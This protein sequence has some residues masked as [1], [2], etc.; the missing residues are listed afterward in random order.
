MRMSVGIGPVRVYSGGG[1]RRRSRYWNVAPCTVRHTRP[2]ISARCAQCQRGRAIRSANVA[3]RRRKAVA[4]AQ[5]WREYREQHDGHMSPSQKA[6]VA[7]FVSG[8]ILVLVVIVVVVVWSIAANNNNNEMQDRQVYQQEC[9]APYGTTWM[10]HNGN[11][12]DCSDAP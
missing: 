10:D 9:Q 1:R 3:Y 7:A 12:R 2:E 8:W 4:R 5:A 6:Y 11:I